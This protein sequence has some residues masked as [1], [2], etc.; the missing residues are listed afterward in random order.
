MYMDTQ[1]LKDQLLE[2]KRILENELN[3]LGHISDDQSGL[4]DTETK[5]SVDTADREDVALGIEEYEQN[6]EIVRKLETQLHEVNL[7]L[8]KIESGSYGICEVDGKE[9]E[10]DRLQANPSARTCKAH[11]NS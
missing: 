6:Q 4:W 8:S 10:S 11:M 5:G 2:E 7:A 9:I 1:T 3:T